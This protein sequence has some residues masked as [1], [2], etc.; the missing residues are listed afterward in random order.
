MKFWDIF[1]K[2]LKEK[3][4][5]IDIYKAFKFLVTNISDSSNFTVMT[6]L[7]NRYRNCWALLLDSVIAINQSGES[8]SEDKKLIWLQYIYNN[9]ESFNDSTKIYEILDVYL[10]DAVQKQSVGIIDITYQIIIEKFDFNKDSYCLGYIVPILLSCK[11]YSK[12]VKEKLFHS[13]ENG[14]G[15]W[16]SLPLNLIQKIQTISQIDKDFI[17]ELFQKTYGYLKLTQGGLQIKKEN[18]LCSNL[19][20]SYFFERI[21]DTYFASAQLDAAKTIFDCINYQILNNEF[22]DLSYAISNNKINYIDIDDYTVINN[23]IT[24]TL[25]KNKYYKKLLNRIFTYLQAQDSDTKKQILNILKSSNYSIIIFNELILFISNNI[26]HFKYIADNL[27]QN[28]IQP[29]ITNYYTYD[30]MLQLIFTIAKEENSKLS[31]KIETNLVNL[32][33][34]NQKKEIQNSAKY[35]LLYIGNKNIEFN[36]EKAQNIY[37]QFKAEQEKYYKKKFKIEPQKNI[38]IMDDIYIISERLSDFENKF[39]NKVPSINDIND[40]WKDVV[41]LYKFKEKSEI[42]VFILYKTLEIISR[43]ILKDNDNYNNFINIINNI[44]SDNGDN[45]EK[46]NKL[47]FVNDKRYTTEQ[48]LNFREPHFYAIKIYIN[49]YKSTLEKTFFTKIRNMIKNSYDSSIVFGAIYAIFSFKNFDKSIL[50]IIDDIL[51]IIIKKYNNIL[52]LKQ[53]FYRDCLSFILYKELGDVM[54]EKVK[55]IETTVSSY[56]QIIGKYPRSTLSLLLH[57]AIIND[58]EYS[59]NKISEL[60]NIINI[61]IDS[62]NE[63]RICSDII[64]YTVSFIEN[65]YNEKERKNGIDILNEVCQKLY[66]S[67]NEKYIIDCIHILFLKINYNLSYKRFIIY[68]DLIQQALS[69]IKEHITL[70]R[71]LEII[72]LCITLMQNIKFD[73]VKLQSKFLDYLYMIADFDL[74]KCKDDKFEL[75]STINEL[76]QLLSDLKHTVKGKSNVKKIKDILNKMAY[77]GHPAILK[78]IYTLK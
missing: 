18:K 42:Q 20:S 12:S 25:D 69:Y 23:S 14:D 45:F 5:Q 51:N 29:L 62:E 53:E 24:Q 71:T 15:D 2:I 63:N 47:T 40:V 39:Y 52:L 30:N 7:F 44:F 70:D 9:F 72:S 41:K 34:K 78:L 77:T 49:L 33:D 35:A 26:N 60:I 65:S 66:K 31:Q 75:Y 13:W 36:T 16:R 28:H 6:E 54:L 27:T 50:S 43:N 8:I 17:S 55:Q 68:D 56:E 19:F 57:L 10:R 74:A 22:K 38:N 59:K 1:E 46:T 3:N 58:D 48:Y 76:S 4:N 37:K 32:A 64:F 73:N 67:E 61:N 21:L 11:K